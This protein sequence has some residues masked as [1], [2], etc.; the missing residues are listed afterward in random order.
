MPIPEETSDEDVSTVALKARGNLETLIRIAESKL[1]SIEKRLLAQAIKS[2]SDQTIGAAMYKI[3]ELRF[4][5]KLPLETTE[6]E[7]AYLKDLAVKFENSLSQLET[8]L[9]SSDKQG[10][11]ALDEAAF[12]YEQ[13]YGKL[14]SSR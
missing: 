12:E 9:A 6:S 14:L 7:I 2:K 5:A 8:S 13:R 11:R 3:G 1:N 4:E 10:R